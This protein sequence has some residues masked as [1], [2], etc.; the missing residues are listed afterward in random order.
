MITL[1]TVFYE[2]KRMVGMEMPSQRAVG[3]QSPGPSGSAWITHQKQALQRASHTQRLME[4]GYKGPIISA[5][6]WTTVMGHKHS[7]APWSAGQDSRR[8]TGSWLL[9]LPHPASAPS[10]PRAL[11]LHKYPSHQTPAQHL[12]LGTHRETE[13]TAKSFQLQLWGWLLLSHPVSSSVSVLNL[14][15]WYKTLT[16]NHL[17][18]TSPDTSWLNEVHSLT[19]SSTR[20]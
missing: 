9:P 13:T 11:I 2:R 4:M 15:I 3:R 5:Q 18:K 16:L 19:N 8:P 20:A 7:E 1:T 17:S 10:L 6:A 12:L 14:Q